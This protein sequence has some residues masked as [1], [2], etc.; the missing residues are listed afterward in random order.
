MAAPFS[1]ALESWGQRGSLR[2]EGNGVRLSQCRQ[3]A[4]SQD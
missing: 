4:E 3:V 1:V 2:L